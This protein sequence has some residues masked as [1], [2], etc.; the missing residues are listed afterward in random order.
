MTDWKDFYNIGQ[1]SSGKYIL[2]CKHTNQIET[3]VAAWRN[4]PSVYV[5]SYDEIVRIAYGITKRKLR[6][7]DKILLTD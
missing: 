1:T 3:E 6:E 2:I 4:D 7:I 5:P